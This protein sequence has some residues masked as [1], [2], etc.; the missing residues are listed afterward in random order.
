VLAGGWSLRP[1]TTCGTFGRVDEVEAS[2]FPSPSV[3]PAEASGGSVWTR[4]VAAV[5]VALVLTAVLADAAG[6]GLPGR[7]VRASGPVGA[8]RSE[9][10]ET[11]LS[12]SA[13]VNRS[14]AT[15]APPPVPAAAPIPSTSLA[16]PGVAAA[17]VSPPR[18]FFACRAVGPCRNRTPVGPGTAAASAAE[19]APAHLPA[20]TTT[21]TTVGPAV[22]PA[23]Q[24][25]RALLRCLPFEPL[26]AHR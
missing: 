9:A 25:A 15:A 18:R 20:P 7:S 26:G 4:L 22:F 5:L 6:D 8:P 23:R 21:E 17:V 13:P 12:V 2:P 3:G 14:A 11:P 16:R 24:P 19:S 1:G 10:E